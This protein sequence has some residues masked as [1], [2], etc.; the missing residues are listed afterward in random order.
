MN[1]FTRLCRTLV[2]AAGQIRWFYREAGNHRVKM[3]PDAGR[4]PILLQ[5][6]RFILWRARNQA[7]WWR[8]VPGQAELDR[9]TPE[10]E[11]DFLAGFDEA[12]LAAIRDAAF[13]S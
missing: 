8:A 10:M 2:F 5:T 12:S 1:F 13:F 3:I 7:I 9:I 4:L 6:V 11:A